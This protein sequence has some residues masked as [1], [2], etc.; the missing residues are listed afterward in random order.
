[1]IPDS[2]AD[3]VHPLTVHVMALFDARGR[4]VYHEDPWAAATS[5]PEALVG[6][7][8]TAIGAWRVVPAVRLGET[9]PLWI[10]LDVDLVSANSSP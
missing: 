7:L 2:L 4:P 10:E 9:V 6:L 5:A 1:V 3:R 8:S